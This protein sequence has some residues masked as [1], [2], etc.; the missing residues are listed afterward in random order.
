MLL[1]SLKL[2]L[3]LLI[4]NGAPIL[5]RFLLKQR[6][7][8][9]LDGNKQ[10]FDH[11]PLLGHAKT[12]R[13][14][15]SALLLTPLA[16][17][18]LSLSLLTGLLIAIGAMLGDVL[19]SFIKRRLNTETSGQALLLDQVPEAL[20]PLILVADTLA[21]TPGIIMLLTASF[22]VIELV[23]SKVLFRLHI[24]NRPY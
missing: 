21:L 12:W 4:A 5:A 2:L 15:V 24:R 13:G 1:L 16:A 6:F 20:I 17:W 9:P 23:L 3:L 18:L 11:R 10:W 19:S 8:F 22:V 14:L 7:N